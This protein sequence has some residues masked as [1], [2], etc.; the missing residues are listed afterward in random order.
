V[1]SRLSRECLSSLCRISFSSKFP[2]VFLPPCL[3]GDALFHEALRALHGFPV[4][5]GG[6]RAPL[7]PGTVPS[8]PAGAPFPITTQQKTSGNFF[9][10]EIP[11]CC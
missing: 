11:P 9:A 10:A 1:S 4:A 2:F 7:P 5:A 8:L 6:L 3:E